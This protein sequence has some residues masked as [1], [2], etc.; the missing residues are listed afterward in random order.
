M[1]KRGSPDFL[2][3]KKVILASKKKLLQNLLRRIKECN[4]RA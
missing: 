4:L 1:Q 2:A 3:F